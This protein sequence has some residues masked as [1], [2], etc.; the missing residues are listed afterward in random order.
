ME[1]CFFE[2][3]NPRALVACLENKELAKHL[4]TANTC[5]LE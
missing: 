3:G 4:K 1:V 2:K 5:L